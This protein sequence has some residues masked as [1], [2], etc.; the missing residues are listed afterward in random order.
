MIIH[1]V[2]V[3][4]EAINGYMVGM[5]I[6]IENDYPEPLDDYNKKEL[7]VKKAKL[8]LATEI[9]AD[10]HKMEFEVLKNTKIKW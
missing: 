4:R 1:K 7:K 9:M 8:K 10:I 6:S 3:L 5:Q 2:D